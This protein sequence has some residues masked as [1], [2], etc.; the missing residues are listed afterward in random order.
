VSQ[1][2]GLPEFLQANT[3]YTDIYII[4]Q[5]KSI[6]MKYIIETLVIALGIILVIKTEW[7][8]QNFGSIGWAEEH[9]GTS[10][11]SRLFYKLIGIIFILGSL[12][13]MTGLLQSI[14]INILGPL[15]G[16]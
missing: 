9:M 13:A 7:F 3:T 8:L 2:S 12:M 10:G 6:S 11:G 4:N 16:I 14:T 15:F 5:Y 1:E